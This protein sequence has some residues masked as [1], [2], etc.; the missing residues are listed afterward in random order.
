MNLN[1]SLFDRVRITCEEE[2]GER[3][4]ALPCQHDN[5]RQLGHYRAPKGRQNE[6][7]YWNFCLAHVREYNSTYNY[8]R[9]MNDDAVAAFQKDAITGHRPTWHM[10]AN[11]KAEGGQ[12]SGFVPDPADPLDHFRRMR[13]GA[14]AQ[15]PETPRYG[16]VAV[17]A[18]QTLDLDE[19]ADGEAIRARYLV[20]VKRLH[21]DANGGDRSRE[22][23]LQEII[24][25]YN[26][27]K[28][29]GLV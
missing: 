14:K 7:Q 28:S 24:S 15:E 26:T 16:K 22:A 11:A 27:L 19:T 3:L 2:A 5:C 10:G 8:F 20:L 29:A 13:R 18:L 25:A 1:S 23:R 4:D 17:K 6:G 12:A 9:G 21:P